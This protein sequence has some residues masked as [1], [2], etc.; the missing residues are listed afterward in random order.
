ML[1]QLVRVGLAGLRH[2]HIQLVID[3]VRRR[4]GEAILV[5]LAEPDPVTRQ[6]Y[7]SE[8]ALPAYQD[9]LVLLEREE[10]DVVAVAAVG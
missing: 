4:S 9:H 5:G 10:P 8:L 2:G 7:A 3:E 1:D 6:R